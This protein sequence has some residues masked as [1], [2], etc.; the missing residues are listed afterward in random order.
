MAYSASML[1]IDPAIFSD[2]AIPAQMRND[3]RSGRLWRR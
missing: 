3:R 1:P 2:D